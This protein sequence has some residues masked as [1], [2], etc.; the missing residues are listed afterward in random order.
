MLT[1]ES[2]KRCSG[3]Q[4]VKALDEF[5][6]HPGCSDGLRPDCKRCVIAKSRASHLKDPVKTAAR[7]KAWRLANP[8]KRKSRWGTFTEGQKEKCRASN[9]RYL[10]RNPGV[11]RFRNY[12]TKDGAKFTRK[13]FEAMVVAQGGNCRICQLPPKWGGLVVDHNHATGFVR[14]LLCRNCNTLLGMCGENPTTLL[15]ASN[16]IKIYEA[17]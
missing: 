14:G 12:R 9:Q 16:Y 17:H 3:C 5:Y 10:K 13:G 8:D 6:P 15:M 2:T 1:E 7:L 4:K 11:R